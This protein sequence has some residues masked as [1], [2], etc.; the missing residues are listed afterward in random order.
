MKR[1]AISDPVGY[2][3]LTAVRGLKARGD[4]KPVDREGGK[5]NA[6]LIRGASII[7]RGEALGHRAWIDATTLQQVAEGI[8]SAGPKGVKSRFT[9]PSMSGD[10]LGTVLGRAIGPTE[11]RDGRVIA[12]LHIQKSAHST[13][14]GDL[15]GYTM[16]L[17]EE[18]PESFGTSIV[19]TH[20]RAA[21]DAFADEN[22]AEVEHEDSRGRKRKGYEF[23]SPDPD[24]V[25]HYRHVRLK[26]LHAVDAVDEPAANPSGLFSRG[27]EIPRQADALLSYAL[28]LTRDRPDVSMFGVDPDRAAA[29]VARFMESRGLLLKGEEKMAQEKEAAGSADVAPSGHVIAPEATNVTINYGAGVG[30][31]GLDDK[32]AV[33]RES[34]AAELKRYTD[35]FGAENGVQWFNDGKPF[36]DCQSAQIAGLQSQLKAATERA[37][38]AEKALGEVK[39]GEK[40]PVSAG[41]ESKPKGLASVIRVAGE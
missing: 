35:A 10:G 18:S 41:G 15:A 28:G 12:D 30:E 29:F 21:E 4:A 31:I 20:D 2:T 25:N 39:L 17:A 40:A 32:P 8:D 9:H 38:K 5:F 24:N 11:I 34:F 27:D 37:E 6:G 19:F 3:R 14:S 23:R 1:K 16:D 26:A 33:T 7:T 22:Q 13:P 36:A